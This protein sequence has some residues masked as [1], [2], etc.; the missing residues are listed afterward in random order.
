[1]LGLEVH[2]IRSGGERK[3]V[4][5]GASPSG[6]AHWKIKRL[7][8]IVPGRGLGVDDKRSIPGAG[9]VNNGVGYQR[10][11]QDYRD[12]EKE[13]TKPPA[14]PCP[15]HTLPCQIHSPVFDSFKR[16]GEERIKLTESK[17]GRMILRRFGGLC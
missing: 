10:N 2:G 12:E 14:L 8:G 6:N 11:N 4:R 9:R 16:E 13:G 15:F 1:M 7:C 17:V 3:G 5:S